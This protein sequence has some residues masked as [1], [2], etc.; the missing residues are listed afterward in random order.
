MPIAVNRAEVQELVQE[1]AQLVE[2]LPDE[3]YAEEHLPGAIH[4]PL[5]SLTVQAA[6]K[7]DKTR[8]VI[9]YCWDALCDLSPRAAQHLERFGFSPVYDYT[10]GKADWIAAGLPTEGPGPGSPRVTAAMVRDLPTCDPTETVAR[11]AERAR[12][13]GWEMAVAVNDRGIVLGRLRLARVDPESTQPVDQVMEPGP[14]TVHG[15][16]D[17]GEMQRR[18]AERHVDNLLVSTPDGELLGLVHAEGALPERR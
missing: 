2:V 16:A 1:G 7:L 5:K 17:L 12:K 4:L 18:L 10:T 13:M 6:H 14:A 15:G 11:V 8:P 9:V 3:E